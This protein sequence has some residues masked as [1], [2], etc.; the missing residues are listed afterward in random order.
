M[1]TLTTPHDSAIAVHEDGMSICFAGIPELEIAND[2]YGLTDRH[3]GITMPDDCQN[4]TLLYDQFTIHD[5]QRLYYWL[6]VSSVFDIEQAGSDIAKYLN[7]QHN[8]SVRLIVRSVSDE[9]DRVTI[10]EPASQ[11]P[12]Q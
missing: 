1:I 5:R 4:S 2:L 9:P 3:K 7:E 11:E 10:Y 8:L 6:Y 12:C